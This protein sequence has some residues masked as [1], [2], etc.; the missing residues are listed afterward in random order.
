MKPHGLFLGT[1]CIALTAITF[2]KMTYAQAVRAPALIN[3]CEFWVST[4]CG[5]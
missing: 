4:I 2:P 3:E 1:V 5:A